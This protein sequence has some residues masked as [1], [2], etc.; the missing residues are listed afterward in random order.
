MIQ[1]GH[2]NGSATSDEQKILANLIF[3]MYSYSKM[4]DI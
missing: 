3:Y 2:S 4:N 1:T